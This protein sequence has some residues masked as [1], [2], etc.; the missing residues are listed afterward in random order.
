M[1]KINEVLE[2]KYS[3]FFLIV[4]LLASFSLFYRLGTLPVVVWDEARNGVTAYEMLE[5]RDFILT[6][7]LDKTDYWNT[8]PPLLFWLIS[9]SYKIFGISIFSMRFPS[10]FLSLITIIIT[11]LIAL[12]IYGKKVSI[13][14]GII[15][16]TCYGF[17]NLHSARSGNF[18]S[19]FAFFITLSIFFLYQTKK[20]NW[21][22]YISG[23]FAGIGFMTKSLAIM[24]LFGIT[25]FYIIATNLKKN[26]KIKDFF[27]YF[28]FFLL[29]ILPWVV[30]RYKIDGLAFFKAIIEND[31]LGRVKSGVDMLPTFTLHYFGSIFGAFFPWSIVFLITP[32]YKNFLDIKRENNRLRLS[33]EL[34]SF[35]NEPLV[36]IWMA[37]PFVFF[38]L[39]TTKVDWYMV[40]AY[41][42]FAIFIAWHLADILESG[43]ELCKKLIKYGSIATVLLYE[44]ALVTIIHL[45]SRPENQIIIYELNHKERNKSFFFLNRERNQDEVFIAKVIKGFK[46]GY[47]NNLE[48]FLKISKEGDLLF[49]KNE[50][51]PENKRLEIVSK[52]NK[53]SIIRK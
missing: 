12:K 3:V 23:F 14:T 30:L 51:L 16:S 37:F 49:L 26:L 25:F 8:K 20:H 27:F 47:V 31:L 18:D 53:F 45:Q 21:N 36:F 9:L 10:A 6:T 24:Q 15:L 2:K 4:V 41:P 5:T 32:F 48:E 39:I 40:P 13:L 46:I 11:M 7:Y 1:T 17:L 44:S 29:P 34:N 35:Y 43:N 22:F 28:I 33:L 50:D 52:N 19:P 42:A 38:T